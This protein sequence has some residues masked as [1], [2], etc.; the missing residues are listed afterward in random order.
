M[1]RRSPS[2]GTRRPTRSSVA[3]R[4]IVNES[5]NHDTSTMSSLSRFLCL[6]V[7]AL[8]DPDS[9]PVHGYVRQADERLFERPFGAETARLALAAGFVAI[10]P[11]VGRREQR[12]VRVAVVR[13][14]GG[15][16]ADCERQHLAGPRLEVQA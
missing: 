5:L 7:Y 3:W 9:G 1:T 8:Q 15:A 13:E 12:F 6:V 16:D 2:C 4:D 11:A 14:H 10:H